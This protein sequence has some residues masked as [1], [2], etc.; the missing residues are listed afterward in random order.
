MLCSFTEI[1]GVHGLST[2]NLGD[3][4]SSL[5]HKTELSFERQFDRFA[6]LLLLL[7]VVLCSS[8]GSKGGDNGSNI[9]FL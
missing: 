1:K 7:H 2:G 8:A 9:Q 5:S 4:A 6:L 3:P